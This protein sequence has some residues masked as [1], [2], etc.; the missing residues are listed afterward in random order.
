[1]FDWAVPGSRV[2]H[3]KVILRKNDAIF[4]ICHGIGFSAIYR[5]KWFQYNKSNNSEDN[6]NKQQ[7]FKM[8]PLTHKITSNLVVVKWKMTRTSDY[9][10]FI[11]K[12]GI[13]IIANEVRFSITQLGQ[14]IFAF[15]S[16][17]F[18]RNFCKCNYKIR[19]R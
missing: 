5:D 16:S 4:G 13:L 7:N 3:F 2:K 15:K 8:Q 18:I 12:C 19:V 10:K 9:Q 11:T 1:M 6:S 14:D 17:F